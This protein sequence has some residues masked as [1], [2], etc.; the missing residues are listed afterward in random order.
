V[1]K[2]DG[3]TLELVWLLVDLTHPRA[4]DI[5]AN[6]QTKCAEKVPYAQMS[7]VNNLANTQALVKVTAPPSLVTD[8]PPPA[9]NAILDSWSESDHDEA[10]ALIATPSWTGPP[11][12]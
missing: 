6:A 1:A 12:V 4:P 2:L 3:T 8:L 9:Q 5:L 10:E 11:E 7:V